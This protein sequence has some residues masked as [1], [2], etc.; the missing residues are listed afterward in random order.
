MKKYLILL[1]AGL[2]TACS[3]SVPN[4][5]YSEQ[6]IL[7]ITA[8]LAP[9]IEAK[10][11]PNQAWVKNKSSQPLTVHYH[12]YWYNKMGV[13]QIWPNGDDH[14][15]GK[16]LLQPQEQKAFDLHKPTPQSQNY[17]LYLQ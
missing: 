7:N 4:L 8:Q 3:S 15:A 5:V 17:R 14:I 9:Q 16:L 12:L 10:A 11:A 1:A 2:L 6:P 13:T